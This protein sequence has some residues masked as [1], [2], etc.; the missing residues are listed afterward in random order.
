MW[1]RSQSIRSPNANYLGILARGILMALRCAPRPRLLGCFHGT[2]PT[3]SQRS[4]VRIISFRSIRPVFRL[5][6]TMRF[7]PTASEIFSEYGLLLAVLSGLQFFVAL[8]PTPL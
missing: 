8:S 1:S 3:L 4:C 6:S 5:W 2:S 7:P